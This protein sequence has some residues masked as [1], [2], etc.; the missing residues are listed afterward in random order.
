MTQE[1]PANWYFTFGQSH[2]NFNKYV[3]IH[4]THDEAREEM[5]RRYG[6]FWSMQ[7][8]EAKALEAIKRW[9]WTVVI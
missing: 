7:Y 2:A 3:K 5:F 6:Q 9:G 4:G 8:A 1:T